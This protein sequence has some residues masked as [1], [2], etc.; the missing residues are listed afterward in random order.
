MGFGGSF[1]GGSPASA[2]PADYLGPIATANITWSAGN[3]LATGF[4]SSWVKGTITLQIVI[5]RGATRVFDHT[6]KCYSATSCKNN[7]SPIV[8]GCGCA[9]EY[10]MWVYAYGPNTHGYTEVSASDYVI[11]P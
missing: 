1:A 9:G 3:V 11:A 8:I 6:Y 5:D 4:T 10:D 7:P 2:R